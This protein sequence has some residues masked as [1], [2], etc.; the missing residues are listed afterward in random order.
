MLCFPAVVLPHPRQLLVIFSLRPDS[1]GMDDC[2][3]ILSLRW[4]REHRPCQQ[5]SN[6]NRSPS[7]LIPLLTQAQ[8]GGI[9]TL[10]LLG[11]SHWGSQRKTRWEVPCHSCSPSSPPFLPLAW[12]RLA[13]APQSLAGRSTL[14]VQQT[15]TI[16]GLSQLRE[17][18][19]S[20]LTTAPPQTKSIRAPANLWKLPRC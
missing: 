18:I 6:R 1:W 5:V 9:Y 20:N 13:W 4:Q 2:P 7:A 11:Y 16:N 17:T 19:S 8:G 3:H 14:S 10:Q 12:P 15:L